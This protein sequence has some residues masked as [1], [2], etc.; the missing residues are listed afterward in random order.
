[1]NTLFK[2]DNYVVIDLFEIELEANEGYLRFHGSK[3]LIK[4]YFSKIKNISLFLA[5]FRLL[6]IRQM[7][8]R[9]D[10]KYKLVT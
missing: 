3:I 1:M 2:L 5:S 10:R 8:D 9:A 7:V 4:I 6:K